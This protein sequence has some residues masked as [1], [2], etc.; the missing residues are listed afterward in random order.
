MRV[1]MDDISRG[2]IPSNEYIKQQIRR[3]SELKINHMSYYIEHVV[4]T[5]SHPGFAPDGGITVEEFQEIS[6]YAA[7]YHITVIGRLS[8]SATSPRS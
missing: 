2:P 1:V 8:P 6:D 3:Y 7:D 5:K 4:K